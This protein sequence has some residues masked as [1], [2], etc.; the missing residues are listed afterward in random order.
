MIINFITIKTEKLIQNDLIHQNL[1]VVPQIFVKQKGKIF[2]TFCK[3][4]MF[5]FK[6][7]IIY[8][9]KRKCRKNVGNVIYSSQITGDTSSLGLIATILDLTCRH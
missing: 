3:M 2:I 5:D 9:R 7:W 1:K 4:G 8:K 6:A